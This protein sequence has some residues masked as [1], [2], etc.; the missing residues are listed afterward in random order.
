MRGAREASARAQTTHSLDLHCHC[1]HHQR[2]RAPAPVVSAGL[3]RLAL[4]G[5][6]IHDLPHEVYRWRQVMP[7]TLSAEVIGPENPETLAARAMHPSHVKLT[8]DHT[9][10]KGMRHLAG[11]TAGTSAVAE[12]TLDADERI[13]AGQCAC[14]YFYTG[15]LKKG[16][17][18]HLQAI[19]NKALNP[20]PTG[21][22]LEAW[23]KRFAPVAIGV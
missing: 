2:L 11:K 17:C 18:R 15:G 12:V 23:Y 22:T 5:Q 7:V 19:R 4:L 3:N 14:S 13:V 8:L 9:D 16:P 21:G 20:D 10:A 6:V 1:E